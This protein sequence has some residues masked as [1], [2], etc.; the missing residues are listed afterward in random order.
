[1]ETNLSEKEEMVDPKI[2]KQA[3]KRVAFKT[4]FIIYLLA[5]AIIWI[6]YVFV[7]RSADDTVSTAVT[8][9]LT[10]LRFAA[11][12]TALWTVLV[13]AHYLFVYKLNNNMLDKEIKKV[14]KEIEKKK[15]ELE[16]LKAENNNKQD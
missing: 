13:I 11:F 2:Y 16:L 5:M 15:A 8:G 14:K 4:H 12:V 10:Y 1:M 7:F 3:N 9:A 6:L